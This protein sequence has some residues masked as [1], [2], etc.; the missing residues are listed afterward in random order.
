[1]VVFIILFGWVF[2]S[3]WPLYMIILFVTF[4]QD[5]LFGYCFLSKWE[6]ALRRAVDPQLRYDW[7]FSSYYTYQ[8]TRQRLSRHFVRVAGLLFLD[9]SIAIN[10]Y[11]HL[12]P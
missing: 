9:F 3:M 10:L 6:F 2:P 4:V 1:M 11:F 5:L 12:L 8:L 7:S